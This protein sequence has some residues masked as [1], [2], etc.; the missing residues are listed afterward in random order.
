[1]CPEVAP[2]PRA[3]PWHD[4]EA[5]VGPLPA[6]PEWHWSLGALESMILVLTRLATIAVGLAV[7]RIASDLGLPWQFVFNSGV[8]SHWQ[9]WFALGLLFSGGALTLSRRLQLAHAQATHPD[10]ARAA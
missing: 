10:Q 6:A 3:A 2:T 5:A 4:E 9:V 8:L 7:W 1:M